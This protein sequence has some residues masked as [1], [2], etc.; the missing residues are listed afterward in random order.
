MNDGEG[1]ALALR[2]SVAFF[3]VAR[4]PV[5]RDLHRQEAILGPLGPTCL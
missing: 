3:T 4:G 2:E 5:T 1:Q